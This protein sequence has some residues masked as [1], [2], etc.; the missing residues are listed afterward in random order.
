[1]T[2][3]DWLVVAAGAA[4]IAAINWYFLAGPKSAATAVVASLG[5]STEIEVRG[6]Y[7]PGTVRAKRGVPLRLVFSRKEDSS[8]SEEVLIP[9]LRVKRFLPAYAKT[10][11]DVMP[12]EVGTFEI[13]CG[14]GMLHGQLVVED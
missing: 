12:D 14:M 2:T 13:T 4:P 7:N 10:A 5:Q 3:Q 1:M 9:A 6:G 8:C 11:V